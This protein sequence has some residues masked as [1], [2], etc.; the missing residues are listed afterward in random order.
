MQN[1]TLSDIFSRGFPAGLPDLSDQS[2]PTEAAAEAT[3]A[4]VTERDCRARLLPFLVESFGIIEEA[5]RLQQSWYFGAVCAVATGLLSGAL[6]RVVV[7]QPPGT[8]KSI[9]W[10][11]AFPAWTW[12]ETPAVRFLFG[13]HDLQ[14]AARDAVYCRKLIRSRWY[15]EMFRPDWTLAGD[16][17]AKLFYQN[18]KGGH[19]L[20]VATGGHVGGKK[21][22]ILLGDDIHDASAVWSKKER[23]GA[24]EW[25]RTGFSDRMMNFRTSAIG[26]IGHRIHKEDLAG[27][28]IDEGWPEFRLPEQWSESLRKTWPVAVRMEDGTVRTSDPR[29]KEG[30]WLRPERFADAE[31][32]DRIDIAGESNYSARHQQEPKSRE[33]LMF[34][35]DKVRIV[36][37]YPVG[38]VAVRYWDTAASEEDAACATSGVLIGRTPEGRTIIIDRDYGRWAPAERNQHMRG[39]GLEDMKRPGLKFKRLYW[40]KGTSDSG[41]ERDQ[42]LAR[43]LMGIPCAAD[44]AKGPKVQR[45]EALS[46]QWEAGNVDVVEFDGYRDYLSKMAGF[47]VESD[48]DDADA[49]S[50]GFNKLALGAAGDG[51]IEAPPDGE[52]YHED[53]APGTYDTHTT[54]PYA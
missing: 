7:T 38:T 40:E 35:P 23:D 16:Q 46:A 18:T 33:G 29:T 20:S 15:Q 24:K 4:A 49:S 13:T 53:L 8:L 12:V 34:D 9:T 45:A 19:R 26:L 41:K 54:D 36:P 10:G 11:V 25:F 48:K 43:V 44:K 51:D 21:G 17:D 2:L 27:E 39:R 47:P 50:G 37:T 3:R 32:K 42:L 31:R 30:E 6:R 52:T 14:N 1:L 28:L 5:T 22:H